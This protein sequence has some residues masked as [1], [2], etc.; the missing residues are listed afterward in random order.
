ML[1]EPLLTDAATLLAYCARN[2]ERFAPWELKRPEVLAE[3]LRWIAWRR[4]QSAAGR[5]RSFLAFDRAAPETLA[6]VV[7]L[8]AITPGPEPSAMLSYSVDGAYEG[9]GY[10]SEA[11]A[12]AIA[13]AFDELELLRVLA[14]YDPANARSGALLRRHGF[15]IEAV[16]P[17]VPPALRGLMRPQ[18]VVALTRARAP[19]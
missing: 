7:N 8:D 6:G 13:H 19:G 4:E 2:A 18:V 16:A 3:Q 10:A 14:H 17:E 9:R 1:R 11:V 15:V 5:G 12:A